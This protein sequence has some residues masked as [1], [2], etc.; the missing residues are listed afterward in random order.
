MLE[1]IG[2]H[3]IERGDP[4]CLSKGMDQRI[5]VPLLLII[6]MPSLDNSIKFFQCLLLL[7]RRDKVY[8]F[9]VTQMRMTRANYRS[10]IVRVPILK[11]L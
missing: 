8:D 7:S 6:E 10:Q 9:I 11:F 5:S 1:G 4:R 3:H 2:A